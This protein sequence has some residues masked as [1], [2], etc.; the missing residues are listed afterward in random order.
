M[1]DFGELCPL[2]YTGVYNEV[3]FPRIG[4]VST[5][6]AAVNLLECLS[7][8]PSA[9]AGRF[10][11]GRTVVVTDAFIRRYLTNAENENLYLN[12]RPSGTSTYTVFGT[13]TVTNT[14]SVYTYHTWWAM[15]V[16]SKTFTSNDVLGL[17]VGTITAVTQGSYHL[18]VRY[19]DK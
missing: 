3:T 9:G 6:S 1:A 18:I 2:F 12:I 11:F 16:A 8:A 19:R 17:G 13:A 5:V 4:P 10:T 7:Q 15:T 14:I